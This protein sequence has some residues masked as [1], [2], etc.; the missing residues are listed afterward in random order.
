MKNN[1]TQIKINNN[2]KASINKKKNSSKNEIYF[3]NK[4]LNS[5]SSEKKTEENSMVWEKEMK[6]PYKLN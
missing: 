3:E 4:I 1:Q 6:K 5:I 2:L